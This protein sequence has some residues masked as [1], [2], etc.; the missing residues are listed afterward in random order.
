[1]LAVLALHIMRQNQR[2]TLLLY[3]KSPP[4][5][6]VPR[7]VSSKKAHSPSKGVLDVDNA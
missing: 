5:R 7:R 4:I 6:I 2:S 1:M 3:N